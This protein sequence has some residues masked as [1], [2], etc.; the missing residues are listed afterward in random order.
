[1]IT[2]KYIRLG[3]AALEIF[4]VHRQTLRKWLEE[5]C[6]LV[7]RSHGRGCSPLVAER[8][9]EVVLAKRCGERQGKRQ[10]RARKE[11]S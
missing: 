4:G 8:D 5:D 6:G 10:W 9:L 2:E 11:A 7:F 1:M 3:R